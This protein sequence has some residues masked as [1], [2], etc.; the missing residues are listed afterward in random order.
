MGLLSESSPYFLVDSRVLH[1]GIYLR[2]LDALV[3]KY[4][5]DYRQT[6]TL[7]EQNCSTRMPGTVKSNMPVYAKAL[8][9]TMQYQVAACIAR[10]MKQLTGCRLVFL[11]N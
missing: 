1:G 6:D 9:H 3:S 2:C 8:E 5:L 4:M 11:N 7:T 10:Q